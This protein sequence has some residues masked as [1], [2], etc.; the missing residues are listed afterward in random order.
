METSVGTLRTE[1]AILFNTI[2]G[3]FKHTEGLGRPAGCGCAGEVCITARLIMDFSVLWLNQKKSH[4]EEE[5]CFSQ[6]GTAMFGGF[7]ETK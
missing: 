2:S 7:S 5:N 6:T 3:L 4:G 1:C